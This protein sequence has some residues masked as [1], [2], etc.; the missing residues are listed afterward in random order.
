MIAG[1]QTQFPGARFELDGEPDAHHD[2]VR[3]T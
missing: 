2:V 1:A 3:F